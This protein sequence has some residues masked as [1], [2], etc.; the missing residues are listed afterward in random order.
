MVK[1]NGRLKWVLY[2]IVTH[3]NVLFYLKLHSNILETLLYS[4]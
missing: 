2:S 4:K 3:G 1:W